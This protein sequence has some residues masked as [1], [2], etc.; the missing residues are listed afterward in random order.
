MCHF[1]WFWNFIRLLRPMETINI[2]VDL[3]EHCLHQYVCVN[4]PVIITTF[5]D[6]I[7]Q[8]ISSVSIIYAWFCCLCEIQFCSKYYHHYRLEYALQIYICT[9]INSLH[10]VENEVENII[11]NDGVRQMC[12]QINKKKRPCFNN[13]IEFMLP[14]WQLNVVNRSVTQDAWNL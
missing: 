2:C 10:I 11:K 9:R 1:W 6:E 14:S 5:G 3:D 7:F 12:N 13:N 4:V 8:A